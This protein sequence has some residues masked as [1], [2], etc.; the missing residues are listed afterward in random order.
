MYD[1]SAPH[2]A[3]LVWGP[4]QTGTTDMKRYQKLRSVIADVS[5]FG[6]VVPMLVACAFREGN[7]RQL[8]L[9]VVV[10]ATQLN[11]E[12]AAEDEPHPFVAVAAPLDDSAPRREVAK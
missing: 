8:C 3:A 12:I 5:V 10:K 9:I 4:A 1:L 11:A 7:Y 6:L 2:I